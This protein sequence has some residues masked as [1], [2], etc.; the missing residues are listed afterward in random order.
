MLG[1][2]WKGRAPGVI[3][4]LP[5][6]RLLSSGGLLSMGFAVIA[7]IVIVGTLCRR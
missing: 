1:K 3:A 4:V 7:E 5:S 2:G 6:S